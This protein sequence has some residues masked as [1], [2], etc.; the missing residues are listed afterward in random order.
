MLGK[1]LRKNRRWLLVVFLLSLSCHYNDYAMQYEL[2][3]LSGRS[4]IG[5]LAG[6]IA[7]IGCYKLYK[8]TFTDVHNS[9][10]LDF[11]YTVIFDDA[12]EVQGP[13]TISLEGIDFQTLRLFGQGR[14]E[15]KDSYRC[16]QTNNPPDTYI[17]IKEQAELRV[18]SEGSKIKITVNK[19]KVMTIEMSGVK[20]LCSLMA[21]M[22][23]I[24]KM[25]LYNDS[26]VAEIASDSSGT[27]K[28]IPYPAVL[29]NFDVITHDNSSYSTTTT[30]WRTRA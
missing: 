18:N 6:V 13:R 20:I 4:V 19:S 23:A 29:S 30:G 27:Y 2:S 3:R 15:W 21:P 22:N 25:E 10:G 14:I 17:W 11:N 8:Y 28:T 7:A 16:E 26:K 24:K 9:D 1:Y 12:E 5:L